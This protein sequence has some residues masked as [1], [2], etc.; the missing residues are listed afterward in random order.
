MGELLRYCR[1]VCRGVDRITICRDNADRGQA[2]RTEQEGDQRAGHANDRSFWSGIAA[3]QPAKRS[4]ARD[5]GGRLG[6]VGDNW[7]DVLGFGGQANA[8]ADRIQAGGGGLVISWS[9][10]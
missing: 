4:V 3:R 5:A 2:G 1:V 10:S 9:A 7:S 6:A 8:R